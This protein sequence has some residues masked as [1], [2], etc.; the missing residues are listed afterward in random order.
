MEQE[1]SSLQT[2]LSQV[3]NE[4]S[5][6]LSM[7]ENL[8]NQVS[9]HLNTIK[10]LQDKEQDLLLK[11][12]NSKRDLELAHNG[13]TAGKCILKVKYIFKKKSS[14]HKILFDEFFEI[15]APL[16]TDRVPNFSFFD[17]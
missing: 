16:V 6:L 3:K 12:E 1:M 14:N 11:L 2:D 10:K 4:K 8:S 15:A 17:N 7:N 13:M 5:D 9:D